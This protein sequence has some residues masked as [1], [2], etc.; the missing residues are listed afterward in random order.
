M[1]NIL[2]KETNQFGQPVQFNQL[3]TNDFGLNTDLA[4]WAQANGVQ[5]I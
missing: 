4:T 2:T 3:Q 5:F 1:S